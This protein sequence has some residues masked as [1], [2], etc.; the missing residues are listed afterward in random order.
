MKNT[1]LLVR[2]L[3]S[4]IQSKDILEVACGVGEF[5]NSASRYARSVSCIDLNSRNLRLIDHDNIH[6]QQMDASCMSYPAESFHTVFFYNAFAHVFPQW[7]AIEKECRRV[8]K[9]GGGICV[10]AT[11][12]I[13][14][15]LLVKV[16]GNRA[17][18]DG[19]FSIVR[20][21]K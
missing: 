19:V 17:E 6:F 20:I 4:E 9:P 11:W 5:T 10:A 7:E 21:E 13:D 14:V 3:I 8:L 18:R 15:R 2:R 1:D 16:F 12:K